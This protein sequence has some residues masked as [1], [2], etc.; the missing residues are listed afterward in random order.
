MKRFLATLPFVRFLFLKIIKIFA[1]DTKITN[2]WTRG[3]L[4]NTYRHKGYWYYGRSREQETMEIFGKYI[5][6]GDVV[7]EIGGHIGFITQ[8]FSSLAGDNGK[9]IVFEPGSNNLPYIKSNTVNLS[10]VFLEEKAVAD[11]CGKAVFYEDDITGQNNSLL[12]DYHGASGV[13]ASHRVG[14]KKMSEKLNW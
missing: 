14:N 11:V 6:K 3:V 12:S 10:N 8:Y 7:I 9:V 1:F 13:A 2:P 4:L 5:K